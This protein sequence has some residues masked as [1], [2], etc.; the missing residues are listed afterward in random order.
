MKQVKKVPTRGKSKTKSIIRT[1]EYLQGEYS[2][3]YRKTPMMPV[4]KLTDDPA[5]LDLLKNSGLVTFS[6]SGILV[7]AKN[8]RR[9]IKLV[10][11]YYFMYFMKILIT[12][13]MSFLCI[14]Y[15][16]RRKKYIDKCKRE[17]NEMAKEVTLSLRKQVECALKKSYIPDY[18]YSNQLKDAME[19]NH[20]VWYYV[21]KSLKNNVNVGIR[22]EENGEFVLRWIGPV[23]FKEQ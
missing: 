4:S 10:I 8:I 18:V 7:K 21:L 12:V 13:M 22:R 3:G 11:R 15:F 1:L 6:D 2:C 19:I 17:G 20:D 23:Y 16:Y 9:S 5:I 14:R